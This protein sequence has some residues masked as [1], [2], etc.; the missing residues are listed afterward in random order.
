MLLGA[1]ESKV[2]GAGVVHEAG[3]DSG[4]RESDQA[5]DAGMSE[6]GSAYCT[7]HF[8]ESVTYG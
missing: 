7:C 6:S 3:D 1:C 2:R 4:V 8:Q 5:S